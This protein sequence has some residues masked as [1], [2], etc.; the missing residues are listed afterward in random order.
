MFD[1]LKRKN[2]APPD[3]GKEEEPAD[4]EPSE[5][6]QEEETF[7]EPEE[8]EVEEDTT[9][10]KYVT[11]KNKRG[12]KVRVRVK[13]KD[14][15]ASI[16]SSLELERIQGR[17]EAM[18]GLLKEY[19][20]RFSHLSQ[21]IGE[22]RVMALDNEKNL[23][24]STEKSAMAVDIV[25]EMKPEKLRLDYQK[26][27]MKIQELEEKIEAN[28]QY[29]D[30]IMNEV[31]DLRNKSGI[32]VGTEALLKLNEDVKKDLI[33]I[34]KIASRVRLDS[35]KAEEVFIEVKRGF[36]ENAKTGQMI[37]NLDSSYAGLRKELEGLRLDYSNIMKVGDFN[38]FKK[39]VQNKFSV[40]EQAFTEAQEAKSQIVK[41]GE[42][43]EKIVLNVEK[44][45][46]DIS[47]MAIT[48]G[49]D[50]IKSVSDYENQI[51][52]ILNIIDNIAGEISLLKKKKGENLKRI[53][54]SKPKKKA[55]KN[56]IK[57]YSSSS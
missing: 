3:I 40:Y 57:T 51:A 7:E 38:D 29:Y 17:L 24:K 2:D 13:I 27:D 31:K 5:D 35:E 28:K 21:Q 19:S 52:S 43:V 34:Q 48:I 37:S 45:K 10:Y 32:F 18:N 23:A 8:E 12:K 55:K 39:T 46:E 15:D 56:K 16:Q 54:I 33:E 26:A 6:N 9:K 4:S 50:H 20:E 53:K 42:V 22:V 41:M 44:N 14:S 30:V 47:D 1:F 36:A 49:N 11:R 25:K